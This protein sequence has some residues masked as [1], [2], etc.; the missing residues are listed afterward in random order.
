MSPLGQI[1][2]VGCV[3]G[4]QS[5]VACSAQGDRFSLNVISQAQSV[6]LGQALIVPPPGGPAVIGV[7]QTAYENGLEQNVLLATNS[8]VPGQNEFTV[9]AL[10]D[11]PA[12][13]QTVVLGEERL[14]PERIGEELEERFPGV[15]MQV[16]LALRAEQVWTVWLRDRPAAAGRAMPLCLATHRPGRAADP[17]LRGRFG[18]GAAAALRDR[19]HADRASA[20]CLRLHLRRLQPRRRLEPSRRAAA[21]LAGSRSDEHADLSGAAARH[22]RRRLPAARRTRGTCA[23]RAAGA[24]G[25][26][27]GRRQR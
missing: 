18:V 5:L 1:Y 11:E 16:S 24:P 2:L 4:L 17:E 8:A 7:T 19:P 9:R 14:Q 21:A 26:T 20:H 23:G 22:L 3:I 12:D 10:K 27:A 13:N 25:R 15:D 6:P